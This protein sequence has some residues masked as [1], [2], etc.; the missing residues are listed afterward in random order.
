MCREVG[1]GTW[2]SW[3]K[4]MTSDRYDY[5]GSLQTELIVKIRVGLENLTENKRDMFASDMFE[6]ISM[7]MYNRDR[8][9]N[10]LWEMINSRAGQY[11]N[12][13]VPDTEL[14]PD[15]IQKELDLIRAR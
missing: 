6:L 9:I 10:E 14:F 2:V 5:Q 7:A 8:P 15:H 4:K 12:N 3:V 1:G 11:L 13:Y